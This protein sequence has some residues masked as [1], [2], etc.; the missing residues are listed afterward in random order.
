M[1][2]TDI[3]LKISILYILQRIDIFC[4]KKYRINE[5]ELI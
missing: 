2:Q 1:G 5:I 4:F 3:I